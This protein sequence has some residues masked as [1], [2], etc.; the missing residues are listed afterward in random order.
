M[1]KVD[2]CE[3]KVR[4]SLTV[5]LAL[6]LVWVVWFLTCG[7]IINSN[8]LFILPFMG[9]LITLVLK[10]TCVSSYS[11]HFPSYWLFIIFCLLSASVS[12]DNVNSLIVSGLTLTTMA[13]LGF[14]CMAPISVPWNFLGRFSCLIVVMFGVVVVY[15]LL[16]DGTTNHI[17]EKGAFRLNGY[18][19]N[20]NNP[21]NLMNM[22]VPLSFIGLIMSK[23]KNKTLGFI[24]A[25]IG[26]TL[27]GL[28]NSFAGFIGCIAG[29]L[30]TMNSNENNRKLS[31]YSLFFL[32]SGFMYAQYYTNQLPSDLSSLDIRLGIWQGFLNLWLENPILG[33]GMSSSLNVMT[34]DMYG[35]IKSYT[36]A[37]NVYVHLLAQGGILG[38]IL[39]AYAATEFIKLAIK[40]L[41]QGYGLGFYLLITMGI[42]AFLQKGPFL[43]VPSVG[44]ATTWI[45]VIVVMFTDASLR[46][47]D[48]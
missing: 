24:S 16:I 15:F 38:F 21:N 37:H 4:V 23:G 28:C 1:P 19:F 42:I 10:L 39:A 11:I 35:N 30:V 47:L 22:L 32:V 33:K 36:T 41:R 26:F 43:Q 20:Y 2:T 5:S 9:F 25:I 14:I 7:K 48:N 27:I 31:V 8:I 13:I 45:P 17:D 46:R 3:K 18:P 12:V 40:N 34:S 44:W 29:L 6:C